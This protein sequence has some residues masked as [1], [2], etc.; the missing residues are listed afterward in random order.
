M[1]SVSP[2]TLQAQPLTPHGQQATPA[3]AEEGF[4]FFDLLDFVNPL[5]HIP[6]VSTI[7]RAATGDEIS[8]AA[9]IVGGGIFGGIPGL[10]S[11]AANAALEVATGQDVGE[12]AMSALEEITTPGQEAP[13]VTKKTTA[14]MDNGTMLDA[15]NGQAAV[16]VAVHNRLEA[17]NIQETAPEEA[18]VIPTNLT[19]Y[20]QPSLGLDNPNKRD[21]FKSSLVEVAMEM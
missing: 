13:L 17:D 10:I 11:S 7:Y 19:A 20:R 8:P 1:N 15:D 21:Q 3:A 18:L 4:D 2:G 5:Q 9:R 14:L 6:V 12:M 16:V